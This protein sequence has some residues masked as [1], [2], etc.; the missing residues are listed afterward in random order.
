MQNHQLAYI[1]ILKFVA[2]SAL[3][4]S[5]D[6]IN[7]QHRDSIGILPTAVSAV[8]SRFLKAPILL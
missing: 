8:Y 4:N 2:L 3:Y 7:V 5:P 1:A 6:Y